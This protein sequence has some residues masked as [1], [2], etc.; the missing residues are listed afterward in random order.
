M[1]Y[2]EAARAF[3]AA[4]VQRHSA[5]QCVL[6]ALLLLLRAGFVHSCYCFCCSAL[7]CLCP[8]AVFRQTQ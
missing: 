5:N 8:A 7:A 1:G 4:R 2:A 3:T 6:L